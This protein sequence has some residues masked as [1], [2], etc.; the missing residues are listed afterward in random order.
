MKYFHGGPAGLRVG[1]Y[2]LPPS[3]TGAR[4]NADYGAEGVCRRDRVYLTSRMDAALIFGSMAP[5]NKGAVY[6]VH[7]MGTIEY[8]PDCT[9]PTISFQTERALIISV[10]LISNKTRRKVQK[11]MMVGE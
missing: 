4:S 11:T 3:K 8:D 6:E 1:E 10:L 2:I 5:S 9:D 7:P